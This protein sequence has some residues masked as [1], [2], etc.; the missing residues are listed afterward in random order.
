MT[1]QRRHNWPIDTVSG[2]RSLVP[3]SS[4][5]WLRIGK[6]RAL[7]FRK[8]S[9]LWGTWVA[10]WTEPECTVGQSR[11]RDLSKSLGTSDDLSF[12]KARNAAYAFCL[13]CDEKW[14]QNETEM[15]S[16]TV[17]EAC[18]LY[19]DNM[20]VAKSAQAAIDAENKLK[21][22]VYAH[23]LGRKLLED[24]QTRDIEQWRNG[25]VTPKR[26]KTVSTGST[27]RLRPQ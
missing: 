17:K 5:Y 4:P 21:P 9:E 13:S 22:Y 10:R 14:Q 6:G 25:L 3:R 19:I 23:P 2:R 15:L 20:R 1:Q 24:L 27:E 16:V 12:A 8:V 18:V 26:M 7:G 11:Q